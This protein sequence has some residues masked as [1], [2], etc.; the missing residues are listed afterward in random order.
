MSAALNKI[1]GLFILIIASCIGVSLFLSTWLNTGFWGLPYHGA[2]LRLVENGV[3]SSALE[4]PQPDSLHLL[5]TQD[6]VYSSHIHVPKKFQSRLRAEGVP[7]CYYGRRVLIFGTD[8]TEEEVIAY[9]KHS[10]E[11]EGWFTVELGGHGRFTRRV[12]E[13]IYIDQALERSYYY[14][15]VGIDYH[16]LKEEYAELISVRVEYIW[17]KRAGC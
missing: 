2:R 7:P 1:I 10:L 12:S 11:R 16:Q 6:E 14:R 17:P 9:F 15:D 5:A 3:N 8:L 4:L 13:N